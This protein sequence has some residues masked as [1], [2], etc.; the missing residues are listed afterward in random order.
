M[1]DKIARLLALCGFVFGLALGQARAEDI[2]EFFSHHD[3]R[4]TMTIDHSPW[5]QFLGRYVVPSNA[6]INL[7]RYGKVS[8]ADKALLKTYIA[9][10][11]IVRVTAL[12]P[13]EQRAFW[14][15]LY[16]AVTIDVVLD[17]YPV[18]SIKDI[19]LGGALFS[20]GPWKKSMVVIEGRKLSLD[21]IE[22]DI[23][24]KIWRD[25][26]VHYAVNC[27]SISCPNLMTKPFTALE[28][29]L[30]L[31]QGARD[32]INHPRGV[33]VSDGAVYLS[34]IYSWYRA[35][36]GG[37]D[38]ELIQHLMAFA[39]PEL[40]KKLAGIKTIGGYDYDWSLNEAK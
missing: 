35:D 26:R 11:E 13:D 37:N 17:R 39:A 30:M 32:Y 4:A 12:K 34:R 18:K 19:S 8:A 24:R 6:N 27:A 22:H 38:Q 28:L 21:N 14:I 33:R 7:V 40:K 23:L 5:Q 1:I 10:L 20:S 29:D 3:P 36:F 25:P 9:A 2:A 31:T 16:N 15:N